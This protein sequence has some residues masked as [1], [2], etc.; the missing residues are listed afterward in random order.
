[1]TTI[2]WDGTH[3]VADTQSTDN[4]HLKET[5]TDK[6]YVGPDFLAGGSGDYGPL[7]R[8]QRVIRNGRMWAEEVLDYGIPDYDADKNAVNILLV[9]K[10]NKGEVE[11]Y[12]SSQTSFYK[13]SYPKFAI[14][15]GRDYALA[16]LYWRK[17]AQ[18]AVLC[19]AD[20]DAH[21]N[22]ILI[23]YSLDEIIEKGKTN[24]TV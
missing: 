20:H 24:G 5:V 19:A 13:I 3:M 10:N 2:A 12:R 7:I 6:I 23:S 9:C 21:T 22:S 14:G 11:V 18:E 15:S 8:W 4:W 1:M 16:S 17:T